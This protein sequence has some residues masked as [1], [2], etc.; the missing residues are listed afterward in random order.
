MNDIILYD[1]LE[2]I[3]QTLTNQIEN[4]YISLSGGKD[5]TVLH[6]LID[7]ALPKNKIPRVFINTGIEYNYIVDFVKDL[8]K[9]DDRIVIYNSNVNIK[10]ML[11]EKGYPFK[12]KEHSKKLELY[13]NGSKSKWI[14]NYLFNEHTKFKCPKILK[15]QFTK[16][17]DI[18]I[19]DKC[20]YELKKKVIHKWEKENNKH[21]AITGMRN[22]EGGQRAN[23]GCILLDKKNQLLK[24]HPLAKVTDEWCDWFV[25]KYNIELCKLYLPPFNF[26]RTGCKGCPFSLDLQKQL[27]IMELYLPNELKQCENI[28]QPIY[29]EYRR[30]NYRLK[31]N[32]QLKLF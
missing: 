20:C 18:K 26:R 5:S 24:Y 25:E 27:D 17:Y 19:S 1:R 2:H 30:L 12:S 23:I 16:D 6:Y 13:Q 4:V 21:I 22:S 8:Q 31:K 15:Y 14:D 9:T 10:K 32:V 28:W 3:K 11:E 29:Q 7:I